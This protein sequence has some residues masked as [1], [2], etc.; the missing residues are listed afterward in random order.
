MNSRVLSGRYQMISLIGKGG[1]A[2]VYLAVDIKTGH[3]VAVKVLKP[4]FSQ[5]EEFLSRFQREAQM[6]SKVSHHNIVNLLDVGIEEN[7]RYLVMEY[8]KGT[9][10]KE[11]IKEK[12]KIPPV[13][14]VQITIR[15]LSALQHTHRNGVIHR[16]IKPQNILV[17]EQGHIKVADFGIARVAN[18]ATLSKGDSVMGSVHYFSPEQAAGEEVLQTGD[19]YSVGVVL[20]EMLTG[21]VP[22]EGD[23]P[24][25]VAMQHLHNKPRPIQEFSPNVTPAI[26][27]VV[28]KAMEKEPKDR[29]QN[30]MDMATDLKAALEAKNEEANKFLF[31]FQDSD[32][33]SKVLAKEERAIRRR[34][35]NSRVKERGKALL[36]FGSKKR[37]KKNPRGQKQ[38][39]VL[40]LI[41]S[42]L[43]VGALV[44]GG[45]YIYQNVVIST[46]VPELF[47]EEGTRAA[48]LIRQAGLVGESHEILNEGVAAGKVIFQSPSS[49]ERIKKGET[50]IYFVSAGRD[51]LI[52]PSLEGMTRESA[53]PMLST[54]GM[55]L[56]IADRVLSDEKIDTIL[57]QSPGAGTQGEIG[58]VVQVVLSGGRALMPEVC[59]GD[60]QQAR[61]ALTGF[62]L[63]MLR[64]KGVQ[65][66]KNRQNGMI[67]EQF[68]TVGSETMLRTSITL[69]IAQDR[70]QPYQGLISRQIPA[71]DTEA[72][73]RVILVTTEGE[74]ILQ[75]EETQPAGKP[76]QLLGLLY[77]SQ[78]GM[79]TYKI[80]QNDELLMEE[81]INLIEE[82][83][84]GAA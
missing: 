32:K 19:I 4:E 80:Y 24:V 7:I 57:E 58:Q 53:T 2:N 48:E 69:T 3:E 81:R 22:F 73:V 71:L 43:T 26:S 15:I 1:M 47:G 76:L 55:V 17:Q 20:Y 83:A 66:N 13:I 61:D 59:G 45:M 25:A 82:D 60:L 34:R 67:V 51:E 44:L 12:G 79:Y 10:L 84:G 37:G 72:K 46:Q 9:N 50:V 33:L 38:Q 29:Y 77:H 64:L 40:I 14:A 70:W 68:P 52:I 31:E 42:I 11:L 56:E 18:S 35:S 30:A 21:R 75:W 39:L 65:S 78:G 63:S 49:G 28:M 41:G 5:D 36:G 62:D 16:D 27:K 54:M 23:S 74:E 6:A 8:V